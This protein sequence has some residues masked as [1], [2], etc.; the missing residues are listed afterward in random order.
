MNSGTV[1]GSLN[2]QTFCQLSSSQESST[3][4]SGRSDDME[5][6]GRQRGALGLDASRMLRPEFPVAGN[7]QTEK[8]KVK[9]EGLWS[10]VSQVRQA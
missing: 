10:N 5:R 2:T 4:H 7:F 1:L 8:L 3:Q 6:R 9:G